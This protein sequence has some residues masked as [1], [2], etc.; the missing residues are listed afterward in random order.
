MEAVA[1]RKGC[2]AAQIT[3]A[4]LLAQ[5]QDVVAIPGT[6]SVSRVDENAAAAGMT[7]SA[8][9]VAELS[10]AIPPG[11]AAGTRYPAA[12]MGGVFV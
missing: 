4:W 7:L 1:L 5:G 11:A 8:D 2:T 10:A 3:L 6:R 12:A 9:E